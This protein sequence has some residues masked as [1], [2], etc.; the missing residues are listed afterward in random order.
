LLN[1]KEIKLSKTKSRMAIEKGEFSG[2]DDPRTWSMQSL[3]KRG[4]QPEAI[5]KFILGMGMSLADIVIPADILYA[6]N[7][8]IIDAGANRY[9]AVLDPVMIEVDGAPRMKSTDAP[10]HPDFPRR[11]KR[12]IPLKD[13]RI[14]VE[15]ADFERL[16]GKDVGLINLYTVNMERVDGK[17]Q[18]LTK[19]IRM[20]DSKIHW[21]S[22][23]N[24]KVKVVMHDGSTMEALA[25]P[26]IKKAKVGDMVQLVRVGFCRV[27]KAGK[28]TVLYYAHK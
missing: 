4:I 2:W 21:V 23:P 20:E 26:G 24:V 16:Y 7:R 8:K 18:F 15:H 13:G 12:K 10:L 1:I 9:F 17:V 25:E 22:E 5:R 6:E 28:Q 3:Q 27:D 14:Y 11:G 19:D